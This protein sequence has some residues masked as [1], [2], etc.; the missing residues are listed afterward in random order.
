MV[1]E[2]KMQPSPP[3][4]HRRV[5]RFVT[6]FALSLLAFSCWALVSSR[7]NRAIL[8]AADADETPLLAGDHGTPLIPAAVPASNNLRI[9]DPAVRETPPLARGRGEGRG[10]GSSS[11]SCDADNAQLRV[12]MYDLPPEFHFGMLGWDAKKAAAAGAWPDVRDTG[13]VPHYPGGLNLQH[14]V[15]YWLT[16]DILSSTAPGFDGR[17]CVAV[18]VTNA[19]QADVFFVPFFASLSYNRHSKLQGKEKMSRNR[20]LQAELVKYL[21]RQEEWR[22]WGGKDHLVVPHHPN[23]MMQAR[24][25]LSAAMYVLSDFGRYPPDVANLKKDVVA[26]YKHVVRSLRDDESPTFDQRPVLA[27]FQGAI[28]RKDGGKVRQKL[29]QLLKDEKDVHFTY[30]SVR[31]NG[32]RRATKGMA[33]SKFCLNIAGDTPSSN[34][35]FDAIVSHCVPVMIS[36][37]IELPFEDVLDYSEFCVFVR[38][39]DAVRKGFL[40]RLLRGITRDEWNTMWERLKEVAH[41]FEYQYPSKPDDAVQM[42]WG[43]VARKMHSLKLQLHKSG[44]FQRTHSES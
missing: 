35:L 38:A 14:S 16:L 23:S 25:K 22:R 24:K 37:D 26:P 1:V 44:R 10:E 36:D 30:G 19:S 29:Y 4:E 21:A 12:Y 8:I 43:A 20:L 7:I 42:I 39:S 15:A 11:S 5:L 34:R 6:F 13:G 18:R 40:L 2:R 27:Y 3:P 9:S 33:S 17:P 31:Q 28:H 41:H 32:I